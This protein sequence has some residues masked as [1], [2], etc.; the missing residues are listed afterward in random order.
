M[1]TVEKIIY[2]TEVGAMLDKLKIDYPE[3]ICLIYS[4]AREQ[5]VDA[6]EK[7]LFGCLIDGSYHLCNDC[8][9]WNENDLCQHLKDQ[10][11]EIDDLFGGL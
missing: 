1:D 2:D 5:G 7:R 6:L 8:P 3:V 11:K 9:Q 4:I 10:E